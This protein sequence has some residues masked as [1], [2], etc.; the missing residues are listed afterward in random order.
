VHHLGRPCCWWNPWQRHPAGRIRH[1]RRRNVAD[2]CIMRILSSKP[3]SVT[4]TPLSNL[5]PCRLLA[6]RT[7]RSQR[8]QRE[9]LHRCL[10]CQRRQCDPSVSIF[11]MRAPRLLNNRAWAA[12]PGLHVSWNVTFPLSA[13]S[14]AI[15]RRQSCPPPCGPPADRWTKFLARRRR[16][17]YVGS[18]RSWRRQFAGSALFWGRNPRSIHF[19]GR[20]VAMCFADCSRSRRG[21]KR[22][23][24]MLTPWRCFAH[25]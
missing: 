15:M 2:W 21:G 22:R 13:L 10:C 23:S 16:G 5:R 17:Y 11:S 9:K 1:G 6:A 7:F 19:I 4:A 14:L 8:T 18:K 12:V 20:S 24:T 3:S 25:S